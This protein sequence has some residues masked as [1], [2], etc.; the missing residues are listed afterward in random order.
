MNK[1]NI[2]HYVKLYKGILAKYQ[3]LIAEKDLSN[4]YQ[5]ILLV[6]E[7]DDL[8]DL[9]YRVPEGNKLAKIKEAMI[10]LMPK[11]NPLSLQAIEVLFQ[12]MKDESLLGKTPSWNQY[13]KV[14]SQSI[15]AGI[16]TSYLASVM[17]IKSSTWFS[18]SIVEFN[19]EINC[20]IRIANDYLDISV[21]KHREFPEKFQLKTKHFFS[22]KSQFKIYLF[23]KYITHKISYFLYLLRF[24]YLKLASD[25][26]DYL[27]AILC[28]ESVLDWAFKVYVIDND[29]CQ[30]STTDLSVTKAY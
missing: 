23:S 2:W 7:L 14:A 19:N 8:Y 28:L 12:A 17:E 30:E 4:I 10:V 25:W 9:T 15:G 1:K 6:F 20:L 22:H 13:L 5:L 29:S 16:I 3:I 21:D 11:E 27:K 26:R 24:K 18:K